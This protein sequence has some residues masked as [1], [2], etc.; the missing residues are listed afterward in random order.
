[1]SYIINK[2]GRWGEK[3]LFLVDR[4]MTKRKWWSD[5]ICDA[6]V[7]RKYSAAKIQLKKLCFG[8]LSVI[9]LE[10]ARKLSVMNEHYSYSM[11]DYDPDDYDY[12]LEIQNDD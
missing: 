11:P 9:T 8:V 5:D 1:M 6:M 12:L 4:K 10:K 7:F 3:H 2:E